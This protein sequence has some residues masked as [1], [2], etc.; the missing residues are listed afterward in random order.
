MIE[1]P[2]NHLSY[3]KLNQLIDNLSGAA[4]NNEQQLFISTHS[5][6]VMNRLGLK[7]IMLAYSGSIKSILDLPDET[8]QYFRKL[9]GFDTLRLILSGKIV[10]VEGA[11][12]EIVFERMYRDRFGKRPVDDGIDVICMRGLSQKNCLTLV[13]AVD[14]KCALL[15]DNDGKGI[16]EIRAP[17]SSLLDDEKRRLFVGDTASGNTL[18]TQIISYN[19]EEQLRAVLGIRPRASIETW[20]LNNKTEAAIC[21]ADS[22]TS[23][24]SPSYIAEAIEF[25]HG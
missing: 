25:I 1:E 19:S 23:I 5:S 13:Q 9:P 22:Q 21:I 24:I 2:E 14:K 16:D 6:F 15:L 8:V 11:S 12:D 7:H 4:T 17:L 10:L 20:M 18:E 3:P